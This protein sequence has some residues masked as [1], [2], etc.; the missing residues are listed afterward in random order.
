[1]S[2]R[3]SLAKYGKMII[4]IKTVYKII[5][6]FLCTLMNSFFSDKK[7]KLAVLVRY[8]YIYKYAKSAGDNIYI[9][10]NVVLKNIEKVSFGTNIS[11][12][13]YCYIDGYGEIEIGDDVSIAHSSSLVSF[14]HTYE[15]E[16]IPIKYNVVSTGKIVICN[17][18]WI[19]SG[20]RV[21]ANSTINNR[22][23]VAANAV[24]SN[25]ELKSGYLYG[26]VPS[27]KIKSISNNYV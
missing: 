6:D 2:G 16:S 1:M 26:G 10:P 11:I 9:A 13:E 8:L 15:D 12:H 17:D 4:W 23:I 27:Q 21:L 22:V 19:A 3:E 5:P 24:V 7:S 14:N 25:S 18:V 20:V